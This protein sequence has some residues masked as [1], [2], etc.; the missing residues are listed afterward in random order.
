M[1]ATEHILINGVNHTYPLTIPSI[2]PTPFGAVVRFS[3]PSSV[4]KISSIPKISKALFSTHHL[5]GTSKTKRHTFNSHAP[6]IPI[7]LQHTFVNE[8]PV[9]WV[10]KVG[11]DDEATEIYPG[12]DGDDAVFG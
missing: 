11:F 5:R 4:I 2:S 1:K 7:L 6:N 8:V 3:Y 9:F 12:F 10:F